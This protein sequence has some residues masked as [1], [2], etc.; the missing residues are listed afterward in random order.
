M[1]TNRIQISIFGRKYSNIQIYSNICFN[2]DRE[3][4]KHPVGNHH[5]CGGCGESS[6]SSDRASRRKFCPGWNKYCQLCSKRGH[7]QN[8]CRT[9]MEEHFDE[10]EA[11]KEEDNNDLTFGEIAGLVMACP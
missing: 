3:E 4:G 1:S 5:P 8:V 11:I 7:L 2:T 10:F 9:T 6:H